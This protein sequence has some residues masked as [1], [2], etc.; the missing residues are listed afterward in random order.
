MPIGMRQKSAIHLGGVS[1]FERFGVGMPG[2]VPVGGT[3]DAMVAQY[4]LEAVVEAVDEY[5][6]ELCFFHGSNGFTG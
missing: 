5:D 1:R 2:V 6:C 4:I 3:S